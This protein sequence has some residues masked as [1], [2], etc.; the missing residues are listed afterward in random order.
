MS[1]KYPIGIIAKV[2]VATKNTQDYSFWPFFFVCLYSDDHVVFRCLQHDKKGKVTERQITMLYSC[3]NGMTRVGDGTIVM[4]LGYKNTRS[5]SAHGYFVL[6]L[7]FLKQAFNIIQIHVAILIFI[8]SQFT[9]DIINS[10]AQI[11]IAQR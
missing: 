5:S 6:V 8:Q 10:I 3:I 4:L 1:N 7:L 2:C 11:T 9:T